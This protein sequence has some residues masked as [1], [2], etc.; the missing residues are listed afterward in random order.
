[1]QFLRDAESHL[2]D[3]LLRAKRFVKSVKFKRENSAINYS[4]LTRMELHWEIEAIFPRR[5]VALNGFI[6]APWATETEKRFEIC[7]DNNQ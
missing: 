3:V 6:I 4:T 7:R 1:M 2:S 5:F